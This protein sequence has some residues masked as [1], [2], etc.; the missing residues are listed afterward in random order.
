MSW[1]IKDR[2]T[3]SLWILGLTQSYPLSIPNSLIFTFQPSRTGVP[4]FGSMNSTTAFSTVLYIAE[5]G[6][7]HGWVGIANSRGT[8]DIVW[9]RLFTL[10]LNF[11]DALS[12]RAFL[13]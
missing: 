11:H 13:L 2:I 5:D 8:F 6:R 4:L 1:L 3:H 9:N 10:H 12:Q 7:V